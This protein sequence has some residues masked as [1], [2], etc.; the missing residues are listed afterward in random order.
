MST[1]YV[2]VI[3]KSKMETGTNQDGKILAHKVDMIADTG[4]YATLGP[5]VLDFAVEHAH[6]PFQNKIL[7][8]AAQL[9]GIPQNNL[10]PSHQGIWEGGGAKAAQLKWK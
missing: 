4:A 10:F 6:G 3:V 8:K 5:A 7:E 1:N 9:T 2:E